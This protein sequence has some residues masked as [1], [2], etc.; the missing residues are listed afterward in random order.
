[1]FF[2][3]KEKVCCCVI[4]AICA[5]TTQQLIIHLTFRIAYC[6]SEWRKHEAE[7]ILQS[8]G[9]VFFEH[10]IMATYQIISWKT[11]GVYTGVELFKGIQHPCV[12]L[13]RP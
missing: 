5:K 2:E 3:I 8:V 1:M 13:F 7:R 4:F 11:D 9:Y 10:K 12:H 6:Q